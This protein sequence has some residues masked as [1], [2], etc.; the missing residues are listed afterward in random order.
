ELETGMEEAIVGVV[1]V[2][3]LEVLDYRL[4]N[5]YNVDIRMDTL[6]YEYIRWIEN[7]PDELDIK[8][9][10]LTSDTKKIEDLRGNHLLLFTSQWSIQWALDHNPQLK[11]SEFGNVEF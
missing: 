10:D 4:R 11:L 7:D 5:E 2:L 1:G 3:Q 8:E 9:L 6:P